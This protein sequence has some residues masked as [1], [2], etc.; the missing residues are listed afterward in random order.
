MR[1]KRGAAGREQGAPVR[2]PRQAL[3]APCSPVPAAFTLVELLVTIA[4]LAVLM[5]IALPTYQKIAAGGKAT[6]C[7][8]NLRQIG[9]A[10]H[11]YLGEHNMIMPSLAAGRK[12][13]E[14]DVPVIDNTLD[15]YVKDKR[16][17]RCPADRMRYAEQTGTSYHWN[18]TLNGQAL[19]SLH[20]LQL[21]DEHSR[22]PIIADKEGFHPYIDNKVNILYADGRATKDL[23]FWSETEE[24]RK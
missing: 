5:A 1:A 14:D 7:V 20:F 4:V 10:L 19:A 21:T 16:V 11:A 13:L 9:V 17:F 2:R 6:A 22:I 12:R 18:V 24:P 8:G 15:R 23:K 3:P